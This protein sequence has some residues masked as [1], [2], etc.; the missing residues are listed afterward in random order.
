VEYDLRS[1]DTKYQQTN[2]LTAMIEG[3]YIK[4]NIELKSRNEM[5]NARPRVN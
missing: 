2:K 3:I 4:N 5:H 1:K